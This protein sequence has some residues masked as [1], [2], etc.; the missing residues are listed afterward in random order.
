MTGTFMAVEIAE[1][2]QALRRQL[3]ANR[4]TTAKLAADLRAGAPPSSPR[5]RAAAPI[6]RLCFS[7]TR[8]N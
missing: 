2:G 1:T 3:D 5:S 4:E 7:S 6:M 8:S